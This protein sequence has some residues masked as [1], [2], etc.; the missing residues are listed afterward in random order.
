MS[1]KKIDGPQSS[2][3]KQ[4]TSKIIAKPVANEPKAIIPKI[5]TKVKMTPF[6]RR[7]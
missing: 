7:V 1:P 2:K 3:F 5:I 6:L 4:A